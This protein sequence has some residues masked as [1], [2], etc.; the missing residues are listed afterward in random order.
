[1]SVNPATAMIWK[2]MVSV[3]P[4]TQTYA[5]AGM[6]YRQDDPSSIWYFGDGAGPPT[7]TDSIWGWSEPRQLGSAFPAYLVN[8]STRRWLTAAANHWGEGET[9]LR[10]GWDFDTEDGAGAFDSLH[11]QHMSDVG[12]A[13]WGGVFAYQTKAEG[14]DKGRTGF[15]MVDQKAQ[16]P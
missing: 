10:W 7:G 2:G 4:V 9:E 8:T 11:A 12:G 16:L 1:M 6:L 5:V 14:G 15:A 13:S 3:D